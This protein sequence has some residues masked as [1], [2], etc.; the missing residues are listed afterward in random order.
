MEKFRD[1]FVCLKPPWVIF[2]KLLVSVA[3]Y[4]GGER[5]IFKSYF[6]GTI[7]VRA[8]LLEFL[9]V[10]E[11]ISFIEIFLEDTNYIK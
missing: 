2:Y 10:K 5:K 1:K 9:K 6:M 8:V 4:S 7:T 3:N 11:I